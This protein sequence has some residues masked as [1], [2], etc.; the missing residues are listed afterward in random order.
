M[1]D[2]LS[3]LVSDL[4]KITNRSQYIMDLLQ[5]KKRLFSDEMCT[6]LIIIPQHSLQLHCHVTVKVTFYRLA[7]ESWPAAS[8]SC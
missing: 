3:F 8:L 6:Q 1:N 5:E 7:I 4:S 2:P